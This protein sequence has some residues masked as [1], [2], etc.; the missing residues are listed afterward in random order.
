VVAAARALAIL[1]SLAATSPLA[2]RAQ[3]AEAPAEQ[4]ALSTDEQG[5]RLFRD[6]RTAFEEER[7]VEALEFFRAAHRLT[8]RPQLLYNI[9]LSAQRANMPAEARTAFEGYLAAQP[10]AANADEVRARLAILEGESDEGSSPIWWIVGISAGVL[11]VAGIV[12]A[13]VLATSGSTL[14]A[15]L[16]GD[17]GVGGVVF[18]L[19][20]GP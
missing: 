19:G 12:L 20:G 9:G 11:A 13:V 5:R 4:S 8:G 17:V 10:D 7:Y 16:P 3:V 2:V 1:V 15:P 18:A 14:Q 6:G